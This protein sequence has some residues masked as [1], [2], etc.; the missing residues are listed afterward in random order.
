MPPTAVPR[1][2]VVVVVHVKVGAEILV[3][4]L[5]VVARIIVEELVVV[6]VQVTAAV[7]LVHLDSFY[8]IYLIMEV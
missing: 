6:A 5:V 2:V 3:E 1:V 8:V 7:A 4:E